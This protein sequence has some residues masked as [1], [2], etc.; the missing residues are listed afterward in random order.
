MNFLRDDDWDIYVPAVVFSFNATVHSVN[1]HSPFELLFGR[2]PSL[3]VRLAKLANI[4]MPQSRGYEDYLRTLTKMLGVRR[5]KVLQA[6][7]VTS[8]RRSKQEITGRV[9]FDF[10]FCISLIHLI[11]Y[12]IVLHI[13]MLFLIETEELKF[14]CGCF[15]KCDKRFFS[16]SSE[17]GTF[18]VVGVNDRRWAKRFE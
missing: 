5:N 11:S 4:K 13:S 18:R 3:P 14:L 10:D 17:I 15:Y 1:E 6:T 16:M 7:F 9:A 8:C 12:L 2:M